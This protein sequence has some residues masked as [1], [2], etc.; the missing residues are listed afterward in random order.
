[1]TPSQKKKLL[2][3]GKR[4]IESLYEC[5]IMIEH[6]TRGIASDTKDEARLLLADFGLICKGEKSCKKKS[7][8]AAR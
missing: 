5:Y 8:K 7:K 1:M 4:L 2:K 3:N 6:N